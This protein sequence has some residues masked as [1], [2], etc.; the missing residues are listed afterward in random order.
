MS[1]LMSFAGIAL[2]NL[3]SKP[4]TTSYPTVPKEY[5]DRTRGHI[6]INTED[7]VLCGICM[8]C[9]PPSAINVD[10]KAGEWRIQRFDC[11]QCGY[12][13]D[14]CPKKCLSIIPG[15]T[16]PRGE[17]REDIFYVEPIVVKKKEE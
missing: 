3:F 14:K 6:E 1:K 7:C 5:F 17:K 12:C 2:K 13:V 16:A 8:R 4:A 10:R 9:C 15:Y 11:V